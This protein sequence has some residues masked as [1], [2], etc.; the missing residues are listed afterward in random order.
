VHF[1]KIL[2]K[3]ESGKMKGRVKS[4][5]KANNILKMKSIKKKSKL[6]ARMLKKTSSNTMKKIANHPTVKRSW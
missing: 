4:L 3:I 2:L 1:Y 6:P 5:H